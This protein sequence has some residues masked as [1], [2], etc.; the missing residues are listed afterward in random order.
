M[1]KDT[2]ERAIACLVKC[3]VEMRPWKLCEDSEELLE[4]V[5]G[6]DICFHV[7]F[8]GG[9]SLSAEMFATVNAAIKAARKFIKEFDNPTDELHWLK[10]YTQHND[11][12]DE[13]VYARWDACT[14]H[15]RHTGLLVYKN[16]EHVQ[17]Y[18]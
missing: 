15:A 16:G 10:V 18:D 13:I 7:C 4:V 1:T 9:F 17:H 3:G 2:Y 8:R 11:G 5:N 14:A 12:Y 6:G